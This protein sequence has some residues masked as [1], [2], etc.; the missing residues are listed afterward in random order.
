M[1]KEVL[2][3]L[4]EPMGSGKQSNDLEAI[5]VSVT[6]RHRHSS[7]IKKYQRCTDNEGVDFPSGE[8]TRSTFA[9]EMTR[10]HSQEERRTHTERI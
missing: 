5:G 2:Q 9:D 3:V 8:V 6:K 4:Q 10:Q 7:G 1:I